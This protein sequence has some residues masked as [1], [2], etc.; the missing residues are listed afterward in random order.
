[1]EDSFCKARQTSTISDEFLSSVIANC[2]F[3]AFLSYT[4]IMLNSITIQAIRKTLS[5]SRP[6][7]TLL[8]SLAISDLGVGLLAQ[9]F[10]LAL[11][12]KWLQEGY[13][14]YCTSYTAFTIIVTLF[15]SATFF[16][17]TALTADRFL[18][19]HL[20]L[21]YQEL[22]TH[23]RVVAVVL[24][25]WVFSAF[26]SLLPLWIPIGII[27]IIFG[28]V[29][30]VCLLTTLLLHYKIYL[31]VCRHKNQIQ[32]LQVSEIAQNNNITNFARLQNSAAGTFCVYLVLLA[33]YLP[34]I[35]CYIVVAISGLNAATKHL[36]L[37]TPTLLF[38]NSSLNPL[39]YCW[40]MKHIRHAVMD[41][42]RNTFGTEINRR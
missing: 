31:T 15:S 19:I 28:I 35:F 11:W 5:L 6:L 17:V 2:L 16:G 30:F 36:L 23:K 22:V 3:N 13:N 14:S 32:T 9:P 10:W 26:L 29:D 21:R 12:V 20:H 38:L 39:I 33:C 18:A 34:Q 27:T 25:M 4:A 8:L 7:K 1:M 42:L 41:I 24:S 40:K 37:Y